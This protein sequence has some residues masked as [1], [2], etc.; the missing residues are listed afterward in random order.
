MCMYKYIYIYMLRERERDMFLTSIWAS[1]C[2]AWQTRW[3]RHRSG[4][5]PEAGTEDADGFGRNHNQLDCDSIWCVY[6]HAPVCFCVVF[7][8]CIFIIA[9]FEREIASGGSQAGNMSQS[10]S[11]NTSLP[12]KTRRPSRL[13]EPNSKSSRHDQRWFTGLC[14]QHSCSPFRP[15]PYL[16]WPMSW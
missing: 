1:R 5:R 2:A 12:S 9:S 3:R 11:L 6:A 4:L 10:C 7:R 13:L 16:T 14:F 8:C 15:L